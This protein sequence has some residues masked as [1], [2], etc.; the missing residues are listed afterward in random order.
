MNLPFFYSHGEF[1]TCI[2]MSTYIIIDCMVRS[3][4]AYVCI[5]NKVPIYDYFANLMPY[6]YFLD[7]YTFVSY[8]RI[9]AYIAGFMIASL[10]NYQIVVVLLLLK[11]ITEVLYHYLVDIMRKKYP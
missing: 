7:L 4:S 10:I 5:K 6:K 11:F 9:I 2:V 8:E 3:H 1:I